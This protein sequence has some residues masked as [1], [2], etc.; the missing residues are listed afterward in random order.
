MPPRTLE[1][2]TLASV[3]DIVIAR[4]RARHWA[5]EMKFSLVEQTKIVT[6]ASEL[7]RNTVEHGGGGTMVI[8]TDGNRIRQALKLTFEDK[9]LG[10]A[11]VE[12]AMR[13]GFTTSGGMGLGLGGS[14][15]LMNQF[16]IDSRLGQGTRVTV[17]RWK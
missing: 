11:D 1:T 8:S 16:E 17:T 2:L 13:D 14:K 10:I 5:I 12:Q 9:G 3:S 6:A 15:R 4:Q 7:A